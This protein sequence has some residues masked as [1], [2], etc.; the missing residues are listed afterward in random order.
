MRDIIH[1][2]GVILWSQF[3]VPWWALG[4]PKLHPLRIFEKYT[5]PRGMTNL[6]YGSREMDESVE[7][8]ERLIIKFHGD[9][10][11]VGYLSINTELNHAGE[12]TWHVLNN[13]KYHGSGS[14]GIFFFGLPGLV[15]C[16]PLIW[17]KH[18]FEKILQFVTGLNLECWAIY[19]KLRSQLSEKE[20]G[21]VKTALKNELNGST[22]TWRE[23]QNKND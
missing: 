11:K 6:W 17:S 1:M 7:L 14:L 16:L 18:M 2:I 3:I 19:L 20:C 4:F 9:G 8:P 21:H 13:D 5:V 23:T 22:E 15:F 10:N 12:I